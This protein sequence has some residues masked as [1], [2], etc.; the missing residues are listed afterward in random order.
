MDP[1]GAKLI[2]S[3]GTRKALSFKTGVSCHRPAWMT[4]RSSDSTTWHF[5]A[6][7]KRRT[8]LTKNRDRRLDFNAFKALFK[9]M[10]LLRTVLAFCLVVT[11]SLGGALSHAHAAPL[12]HESESQVVHDHGASSHDH[13]H[14]V[15]A[16]ETPD[17]SPHS[18]HDDAHCCTV[19]ACSFLV[20]ETPFVSVRIVLQINPEVTGISYPSRFHE[21]DSPPPRRFS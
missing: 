10:G 15:A 7:V 1:A 6:K 19:G 14:D 11:L 13:G 2:H 16:S 12:S 17:T 5:R 4:A 8:R 18:E 9:R 21:L 3:R 20:M